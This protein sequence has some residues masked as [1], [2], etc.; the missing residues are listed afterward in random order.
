MLLCAETMVSTPSICIVE[1]EADLG[2]VNQYY[3]YLPHEK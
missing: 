1:I 3:T 2:I